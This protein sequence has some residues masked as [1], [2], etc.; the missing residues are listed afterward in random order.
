M[1]MKVLRPEIPAGRRV[2]AVS[3]IHGNLPLLKALLEKCA[4]T[5]AD[6]LIIVGDI[7]E[8]GERSLETLR[9]VMQLAQTH[10]V[11]ALSGNCDSMVL[12]FVQ[13][14]RG[15][16]EEF[17]RWYLDH[18]GERCCLI[19]MG[20]EAG[21]R[22]ERFED[23]PRL[24]EVIKARFAPELAFL[25][26]M[27]VVLEAGEYL[28][29][30]GG[31]PREDDLE[32]LAPWEC[33]KCDDFLGR[34]YSFRKWVVVGHWPVS[35]YAAAIP[36]ANPLV[37]RARHI[38]SIDGGCSLKPDGQLNALILPDITRGEFSWV[39]CDGLPAAAAM[40]GQAPSQGPLYIRWEDNRVRVLERGAEFSRCRHEASGRELDVLTGYLYEL[41]DGWHC[42]NSTDYLLPVAPGDVLGV[43]ERTSRGALCKKDGVT[44]W[45][46]GK[47]EQNQEKTP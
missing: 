35:N 16:S 13:G 20:L 10:T 3:D 44:G 31:V 41:E 38:I 43:V 39:S 21:F 5:R 28:F 22:L 29:V 8:K 46:L 18:W 17:L 40:E 30:H 6:V 23:V 33:M 32:R 26:G 34:G 9:Y 2:L 14:G 36:C 1:E 27:G 24:R 4:F 12:D 11:Y 37:E 45:Y 7:L 25:E 15:V 42:E 19:Q 47:L